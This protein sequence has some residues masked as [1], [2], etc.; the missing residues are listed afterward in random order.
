MMLAWPQQILALARSVMLKGET[1]KSRLQAQAAA[2]LR[3]AV[4]RACFMAVVLFF[5]TTCSQEASLT[6]QTLT[7]SSARFEIVA[8]L[9]LPDGAGPHPAIV[10]VHGDGAGTRDYYRRMRE[11]FVEAGYATLIWDKPGFGASK[12]QFSEDSM[13]AERTA[14]LLRAISILREHPMIDGGRIGVWGVS[15]A[16]YVVTSALQQDHGMAFV[17]LVGP[18]GENGIEQTAYFVGQ[19]V[20]CEGSSARQSAEADSLA[21]AVLGAETYDEYAASGGLL[22]DRY[23]TVKEIGFMA[24]ILPRGRWKQRRRDGESYYDPMPSISRASIPALVFFGELDKNVDPVQGGV[25]YRMALEKS[26]NKQSRV[27]LVPGVDHDM[28][29]SSTG[30]EKERQR[31]RNWVVSREYLDTMLGWLREVGLRREPGDGG[32]E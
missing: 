31:R 12:G 19:Q 26:G 16:G 30:C 28:V 14:I 27:V 18:P 5:V 10:I 24:G 17:V 13:I 29:P 1:P 32:Q 4:I 9:Q 7:F 15:Q 6:S 11:R 22:L 3:K 21:A 25:A 23:P 2:I 20:A 8:D